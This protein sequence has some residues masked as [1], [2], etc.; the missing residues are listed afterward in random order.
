MKKL[1]ELVISRIISSIFIL[2]IVL[3]PAG[4]ISGIIKFYS[5]PYEIEVLKKFLQVYFLEKLIFF[6]PAILIAVLF[7]SINSG[8]PD[9]VRENLKVSDKEILSFHSK[10]AILFIGICIF[11]FEILSVTL[12][13][14]KEKLEIKNCFI[15]VRKQKIKEIT[16][17][18]KEA[19]RYLQ[20]QEYYKCLDLYQ[21][22]LI[23]MPKYTPAE[24]KIKAIEEKLRI[25]KEDEFKRLL[26]EGI[27]EFNNKNFKK[28][29][30]YL[31]KA[32]EINPK[33]AEAVKYYNLTLQALNI[34]QKKII[35]DDY[36]YLISLYKSETPEVLKHRKIYKLMQQA[37]I[38]FKKRNYLKA[39]KILKNILLEN[40][41]HYGAQYYLSLI[42]QRLSQITY[43]TTIN[44]KIYKTGR[45]YITSDKKI[46]LPEKIAKSDLNEYTFF[47]TSFYEYKNN[48]FVQILRKRYG[49]YNH[50]KKRFEF[51]D[52]F[53]KDENPYYNKNINPEIMW[54]FNE[55]IDSPE[56]FPVAKLIN[57]YKYLTDRLE[58]PEI[59]R[60][61]VITK[62]NLYFLLI[63]L[64][65]ISLTLGLNIARRAGTRKIG[66]ISFIFLPLLAIIIDRIFINLLYFTKK[67]IRLSSA[68]SVSVSITII[69]LFYLVF[70]VLF[71]FASTRSK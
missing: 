42:N 8:F 44:N 35:K 58:S 39:K 53:I 69:A 10:I 33:S 4:I 59:F 68:Y 41:R 67:L 17:I 22:I 31:R 60:Y 19:E 51:I 71:M 47:N 57:F 49:Y 3:V 9:S 28:A 20:E 38:E 27:K 50:E 55:I 36:S 29:T 24:E 40:T 65:I 61:I 2:L 48:S 15:K 18:Y 6:L 16:K 63:I 37:R 45:F 25:M 21:E 7:Y 54:Y 23:I 56:L 66:Y 62:L 13:Y 64:F 12:I 14:Q 1:R 46:I 52:S 30:I 26:S 11:I 5:L 32:L 34:K 43:F 70:F